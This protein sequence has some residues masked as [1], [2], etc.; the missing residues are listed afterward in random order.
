MFAIHYELCSLPLLPDQHID[1]LAVV[2]PVEI[3]FGV[4][5]FDDFRA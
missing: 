4:I 1:D 5:L 3:G 2:E